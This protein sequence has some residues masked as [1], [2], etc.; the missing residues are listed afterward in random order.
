MLA[1]RSNC[2]TRSDRVRTIVE[3]RLKTS[4]LEIND[5]DL[6]FIEHLRPKTRKRLIAWDLIDES[7]HWYGPPSNRFVGGVIAILFDGHDPTPFAA[8]EQASLDMVPLIW[9][10]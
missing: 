8:S 9:T 3:G 1:S 2:S 7:A 5:D 6:S 10:C 4:D